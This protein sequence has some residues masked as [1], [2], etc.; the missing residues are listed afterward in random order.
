MSR[1]RAMQ[2][3]LAGL[4][5]G[6]FVLQPAADLS[7]VPFWLPVLVTACTL[8]A[9]AIALTSPTLLRWPIFL[10]SA[11]SSVGYALGS[12]RLDGTAGVIGLVLLAF[13]LLREV[14]APGQ[15]GRNR[16]MGAIALY[17][18]IALAF[19]GFYELLD[20]ELPGSFAGATHLPHSFRYFSIVVQTTI[21]FGD[22]V[23]ATPL[24][25]SVVMLQAVS[26]QIF[27]AVLLARLVALQVE[28]RRQPE[29]R[30]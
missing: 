28:A 19:A 18:V 8:L 14:L 27:I 6:L 22:I 10:C 25:R 23:A 9:G 17:L 11:I 1:D 30:Q 15:V 7:L 5:V 4:V 3:L 24:A 13:A 12:E 20:T 21:G 2:V 29:D 16:I 26:G